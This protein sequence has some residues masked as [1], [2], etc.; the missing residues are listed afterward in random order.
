MSANDPVDQLAFLDPRRHE[1][2]FCR[3]NCERKDRE[4]RR[5]R[6]SE[7]VR[8]T[9]NETVGGLTYRLWRQV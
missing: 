2:Y 4:Q 7:C 8:A 6:C 1:L 5:E 3:E 9:R